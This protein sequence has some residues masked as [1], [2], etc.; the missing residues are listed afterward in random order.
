MLSKQVST[1]YELVFIFLYETV[2][3]LPLI[4]MIVWT[5]SHLGGLD[6]SE[7]A[8]NWH[9]ILMLTG[10]VFCFFNAAVSFRML[11]FEKPAK[12]KIHAAFHIT[13]SVLIVLGLVAQF[14]YHQSNGYEHLFSSHS[15]MGLF[16]AL[17]YILQVLLSL[18]VFQD[19]TPNL[20]IPLRVRYKPLHVVLGTVLLIA[21]GLTIAMGV[22][23]KA[24]YANLQ[25]G[26]S[27]QWYLVHGVITTV[28][29]SLA[30]T[31]TIIS[32]KPVSALPNTAE[33]RPPQMVEAETTSDKVAD[34]T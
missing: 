9:P 28:F 13:G 15:W 21:A 14:S 1:V 26:S 33:P 12:K 27:S 31:F 30:A 4:I 32:A 2:V 5:F 11:P 8:D 19:F 23:E 20:N 17:C 22:T 7:H 34:K 16:T 10:L 29:L 6:F 3:L 24:A 18:G 25:Y